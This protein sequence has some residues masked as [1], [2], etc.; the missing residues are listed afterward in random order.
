ME[1][2]ARFKDSM[3]LEMAIRLLLGSKRYRGIAGGFDDAEFT[4]GRLL[5]AVERIKKRLDEIPMDERLMDNLGKTLDRLK[6]EVNR[7]SE[8]ENNDWLLIAYLFDLIGYLLGYDWLD[9][10]VHRAV[11]FFQDKRQEIEDGK[12]LAGC[13]EEWHVDEH[14][15]VRELRYM[16]VNQLM[17]NKVP[18]CHIASLL[19]LPI[20]KVDKLWSEIPAL[21]K[22]RGKSIPSFQ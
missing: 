6:R 4:R 3:E 10:E 18:K 19:G 15:R 7:I 17:K 9:G 16:L 14:R 5:R 1:K 2:N 12:L 8:G 11:V 21:E 20:G 13:T 22:K